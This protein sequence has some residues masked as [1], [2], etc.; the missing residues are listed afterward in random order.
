VPIWAWKNHHIS[1]RKHVLTH[2]HMK[3]FQ[4]FEKVSA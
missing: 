2:I 1:Q 3:S 4:N